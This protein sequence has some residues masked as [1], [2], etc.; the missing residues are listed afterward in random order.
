M[1][2]SDCCTAVMGLLPNQSLPFLPALLL[3]LGVSS[4]V[5]IWLVQKET[6]EPLSKVIP[7]FF[8]TLFSYFP[9]DVEAITRQK[10]KD[11]V[12]KVALR[13]NSMKSTKYSS[14]LIHSVNLYVNETSSNSSEK[15]AT[16]QKSSV[17]HLEKLTS[18]P[19]WDEF[20][21]HDEIR[22]EIKSKLSD[23]KEEFTTVFQDFQKG[24][25]KQWQKVE[26][27]SGHSCVYPLITNGVINTF[28]CSVCPATFQVGVQHLEI[29]SVSCFFVCKGIVRW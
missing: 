12:D 4:A 7:R 10:N 21:E 8:R 16:K 13:W 29:S 5:L 28:N 22:K 14:R 24:I 19:W 9:E 25:C 27:S 1:K 11:L 2:W 18:H 6:K 20:S 23:I 3:S 15:G 26:L 17:F